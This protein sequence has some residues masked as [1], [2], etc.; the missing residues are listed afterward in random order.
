[1]AARLSLMI[2]VLLLATL[3]VTSSATSC[4]LKASEERINVLVTQPAIAVLLRS[5]FPRDLNVEC[6][7]PP[8]ADPHEYEPSLS[9]LLRSLERADI[10]VTSGPG[11]LAV[12]DRI[13]ELRSKGYFNKPVL[14]LNDYKKYGLR[15]LEINGKENYH[16]IAFSY[17]GSRAIILATLDAVSYIFPEKRESLKRVAEGYLSAL[18]TVLLSAKEAINERKIA[19][20]SPALQYV[21]ND[22]GVNVRKIYL[23]DPEQAITQEI[24]SSIK[25]DYDSGTY[26]LLLVTDIALKKDPKLEDY[27]KENKIKYI[28]IDVLGRC[29]LDVYSELM[30]VRYLSNSTNEGYVSSYDTYAYAFWGSLVINF[31]LLGIVL[32]LVRKIRKGL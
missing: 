30:G 4:I 23:E 21:V 24:L 22:L 29:S 27:L 20:Y 32:T 18:W 3:I 5:A 25:R 7:I 17:N 9:D 14:T 11:H 28:R 8:G 16:G 19:L 12:E 10:V 2:V 15:I 1:M 13:L 26:D 6:L 31:V